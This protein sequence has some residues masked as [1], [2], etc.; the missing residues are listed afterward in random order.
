[1]K[2]SIIMAAA[3]LAAGC[4]ADISPEDIRIAD[5]KDGKECAVS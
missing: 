5:Y 1:M 3:L 4:S 2:K